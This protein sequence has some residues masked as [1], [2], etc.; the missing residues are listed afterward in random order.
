MVKDLCKQSRQLSYDRWNIY[1]NE[2]TLSNY[3]NKKQSSYQYVD[4]NL[5]EPNVNTKKKKKK[6]NKHSNSS[7]FLFVL[8]KTNSGYYNLLI[9]RRR[10][11]SKKCFNNHDEKNKR[12]WEVP[13]GRCKKSEVNEKLK[14]IHREFE[15][16][17][18]IS[19]SSIGITDND[20]NMF[21][22]EQYMDNDT[23]KHSVYNYYTI[24]DSTYNLNDIYYKTNEAESIGFIELGTIKFLSKNFYDPNFYKNF[25]T[26]LQETI[27]G[28]KEVH[29]NV[30]S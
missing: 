29:I 24:I 11:V 26:K 30:Y 19:L 3:F 25:I 21:L 20:I 23:V 14:T 7:A 2:K 8:Q 6:K 9:Q 28:K 16:E 13:G 18:K 5:K 1:T 4:N 15:E 12:C 22:I 27:N 17:T 10:Y